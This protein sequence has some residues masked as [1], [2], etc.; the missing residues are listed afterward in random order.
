MKNTIVM[1]YMLLA[2]TIGLRAQVPEHY[3]RI[4]AENN[5][6]L[7]AS[8]NEFEAALQKIPQ[9][10]SLPDPMLMF[11]YSVWPAETMPGAEKAR[12]SL[13]QMFPWFGTLKALGNEAALLAEAKYQ[14]YLEERNNLFYQVAEAW[15]PLYELWQFMKI[16]Q[17]NIQLLESYMTIATRNFENGTGPMVNVLRSDIILQ[18]ALTRLEILNE[19][20]LMLLSVFNNLL[21]RDAREKADIIEPVQAVSIPSKSEKDSLLVQNPLLAGLNLRHRASESGREAARLMGF[22]DIGIGLEYMA[23]KPMDGMSSQENLKGSLMPMITLSIPLYRKKYKAAQEEARLRQESLSYQMENMMNMLSSDY[24]RAWFELQQ[25]Q[26]L[27]AL[28]DRQINTGRQSLNLLFR[29]YSN[30][31][32][33]FEEV[34]R[35]Q[36]QLLQYEKEKTT[37]EAQLNAAIAKINYI[38]AK[39]IVPHENK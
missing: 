29:S 35:M 2:L 16:E 32:N 33:D 11:G 10:Q 25:Q 23:M 36:Q 5:P 22:P 9:V 19:K 7:Q 8:Y 37:A 4:A 26:K 6:R 3:L 15:L 21:N 28:Y 27:I 24:D 13:S 31:G 20:E 30:S 34:L 12:I 38:T 17:E 18:D 1:L 14:A 39:N